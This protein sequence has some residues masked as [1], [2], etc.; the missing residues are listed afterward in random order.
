MRLDSHFRSAE[1]A[2][3]KFAIKTLWRGA[4]RASEPAEKSRGRKFSTQ[5]RSVV[6]MASDELAMAAQRG[7]RGS[8][9]RLVTAST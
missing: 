3:R 4:G 1:A 7:E 2:A 8:D 9:A 5:E 6:V